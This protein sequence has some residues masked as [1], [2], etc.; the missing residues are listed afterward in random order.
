[1]AVALP[2]LATAVTRDPLA[3]AGVLAAQQLPWVLVALGWSRLGND[4]R[5]VVGGVDTLRA[6]SVGFLGALSVLGRETI[7]GIQLV[8]FVVGLGEALTDRAENEVEDV[9]AISARGMLGLALVGLPL[10]GVLYEVFPAT[11]FVFDVLAF[12]MAGLL[13][14]FAVGVV[15]RRVAPPAEPDERPTPATS[16]W[17]TAI[18]ALAA[19]ATAGVLAVLVLFALDDL[20]LGAPAFGALLA[21]LAAATALGGFLAPEV[22]SLLGLRGGTSASLVIAAT[23]NVVAVVVADPARPIV[24]ALAL[25]VAGA[26]S[27]AAAVLVR[28]WLQ[29]TSGRPLTEENLGTFHL[30]VWAVAPLGALGAGLLARHRGVGDAIDGAAAAMLLAALTTFLVP[31]RKSI[32]ATPEPMLGWASSP[33]RSGSRTPEEV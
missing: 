16:W 20:G 30:V 6:I 33:N 2:L 3:V 18:A 5:T 19:A 32:D 11:P 14:L 23:A 12:A 1:V 31:S 7:L 13:S 9:S 29:V 28:A 4:R 15:P 27:M 17:I 10:G 21:G 25:G 24:A 26:A 8:A 22:G